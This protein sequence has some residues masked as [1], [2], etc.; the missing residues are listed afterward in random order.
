MVIRR[1]I[2]IGALIVAAFTLGGCRTDND[3]GYDPYSASLPPIGRGSA[4]TQSGPSIGGGAVP[5]QPVP[6]IGGGAAPVY[7]Q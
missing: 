1:T 3:G 4:P 7:V 6:T 5:V 2:A